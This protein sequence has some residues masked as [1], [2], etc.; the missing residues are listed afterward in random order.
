VPG[1]VGF[2][3]TL[4]ATIPVG[5]DPAQISEVPEGCCGENETAGCAFLGQDGRFYF[6]DWENQNLKVVEFERG[7]VARIRILPGP[8]ASAL[9]GAADRVGNVYLVSDW[10]QRGICCTLHC[11]PVGATTWQNVDVLFEAGQYL[12]DGVPLSHEMGLAADVSGEVCLVSTDVTHLRLGVARD[13]RIYSRSGFHRMPFG[14]VPVVPGRLVAFSRAGV[15]IRSVDS[16]AAHDL[17]TVRG[18]WL[19]A[20]S[21]GRSYFEVDDGYAIE[22][23]D[24]DGRLVAKAARPMEPTWKMIEPGRA[25]FVTADGSLLLPRMTAKA[26]LILRWAPALSQRPGR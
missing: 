15:T 25:G 23:R 14:G 6:H 22:M 10:G 17:A 16:L 18:W 9:G 26:L 5:K 8:P 19:G 12:M 24:C 11:L 20:D 4:A 3:E 21:L 1:T 7:R 2:V 13:G